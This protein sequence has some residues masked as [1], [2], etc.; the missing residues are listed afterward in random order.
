MR[1]IVTDRV[2]WSVCHSCEPCKNGWTNWDAVWIVDSSG[3]K[4]PRIGWAPDRLCEG[5]IFRGKDVTAGLSPLAVANVLFHHWC[6]VTIIARTGW[7]HSLLWGVM[8]SGEHDSTICMQRRCGLLSDYFDHL[9]IKGYW[10]C[11]W[12]NLSRSYKSCEH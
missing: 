1:L 12:L 10:I 4:H 8:G 11:L 2:A 5:A 7:V 6:C 3:P 9:F